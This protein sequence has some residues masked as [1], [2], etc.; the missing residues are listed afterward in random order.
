[1]LLVQLAHEGAHLLA[2]HARHRNLFGRDDMHFD[3]ARAQR[4]RNLEADEARADHDGAL[5]R[6]GAL[7][8]GAAVV[9]RA[10]NAHMRQIGA[11]DR[12]P[13]RLRA[14]R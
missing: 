2:E 4:G 1:M 13:H 10:Q 9:E 7:D 14:R 8:D 12:Q 5:R 11:R 6:L 3:L